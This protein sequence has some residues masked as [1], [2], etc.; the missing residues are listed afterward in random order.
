MISTITMI[1]AGKIYRNLMVDMKAT[2]EKLMDRSVR[3]FQAATGIVDCNLAKSM[4][5][6]ADGNLKTAIV[7]SK[8]HVNAMEAA[9]LLKKNN[10]FVHAA[11]T[12][13]DKNTDI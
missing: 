8:C 4:I 3:I 13:G 1:R 6:K 9:E 7:M 2:N 5:Q 11:I 12:V 10:H